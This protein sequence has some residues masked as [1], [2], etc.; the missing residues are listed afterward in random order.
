[1]ATPKIFISYSHKDKIWK[2]RLLLHL[3][4]L[5]RQGLIEIWDTSNLQAGADWSLDIAK[6]INDADV[7]VLLLSSDFL[8]SDYIVNKEFPLLLEQNKKRGLIVLPIA[9]RPSAWTHVPELAQFQFLNDPSNPLA[10][11][12][13]SE[14]DVALALAA[15]R[16]IKLAEA[17]NE[18]DSYKQKHVVQQPPSTSSSTTTTQQIAKVENQLFV[19]HS[20]TD[21]D[22]A[23][24]LKLKLERQGYSAWID[25]DRLGPGVDWRQEIDDAIK[26]SMALIAI[27]SPEARESEYVTYEWAFAWGTGVKII[28]IML[29]QTTMHP[30]LA[31]LQFLDFTNRIARPWSNLFNAL[32]I[33]SDESHNIE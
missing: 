26:K 24:L 12:R 28:P 4:V 3:R 9:V 10:A 1:M 20:K 32:G 21:G 18:Q 17:L 14:R 2:D 33:S 30:R 13:A 22:F 23:E 25:V 15:Q 19:S 11:L 29:R 27:M 6:A 7:A 5:E 8:A 16:I 31:T